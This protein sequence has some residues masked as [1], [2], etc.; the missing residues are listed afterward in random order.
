MN[1]RIITQY[2]E[3]LRISKSE[4]VEVGPTVATQFQYKFPI[5]QNLKNT[6]ITGMESFSVSQ[7]TVSPL[8]APVVVVADYNRAYLQLA[9]PKNRTEVNNIPLLSLQSFPGFLRLF[10]YK[11]VDW[12]NCFINVANNLAAPVAVTAGHSFLFTVYYIDKEQK[13]GLLK[14]IQA[15]QATL[16]KMS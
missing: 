5:I 8:N 4:T 1:T 2:Q 3:F 16:D 9:T 11:D 13:Q 15:W 6:L 14:R 7:V 10:D 12:Q